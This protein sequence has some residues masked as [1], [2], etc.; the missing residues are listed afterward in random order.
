MF[1]STH[2]TRTL[3]HRSGDYTPLRYLAR[4]HWGH[5]TEN[6]V[7]CLDK[8]LLSNVTIGDSINPRVYI[9]IHDG[10]SE[11]LLCHGHLSKCSWLLLGLAKIIGSKLYKY[12]GSWCPNS[13]YVPVINTVFFFCISVHYLENCAVVQMI[14]FPPVLGT[15]GIYMLH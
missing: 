10:V 8:L 13:M 11:M 4:Y 14:Y 7:I 2:K 5:A 3:N 1:L 15:M 12:H 9:Y 6:S